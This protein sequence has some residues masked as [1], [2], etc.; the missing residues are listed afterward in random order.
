MKNWLRWVVPGLVALVFIIVAINYF[1][2]VAIPIPPFTTVAEVKLTP[3]TGGTRIML[4]PVGA[5]EAKTH[6]GPVLIELT[7][8][9]ID[10]RALQESLTH[11]QPQAKLYQDLTVIAEA[12]ARQLI[13]RV[14][15]ISAFAGLIGFLLVGPRRWQ[16]ALLG[17]LIGVALSSG[18]IILSYTS[19]DLAALESPRFTGMMEYAPWMISFVQR[20][21]SGLDDWSEQLNQMAKSIQT[22]SARAQAASDL[23]NAGKNPDDLVVLNISDIHNNPAG[24]QMVKGIIEQFQV[25]LVVDN[26]DTSDFGT[27]LEAS[28]V[29]AIADLNVRYLWVPGNHDSPEI[30]KKMRQIDNV[31]VLDGS[32]EIAGLKVAGWPDP[33]A[34]GNDVISLPEELSE[35]TE[36]LRDQVAGIELDFLVVHNHRV[37]QE[38]AGY[39][40][41]ILTGHSHKAGWTKAGETV[42]VNPGSTGAEGI[43]GLQKEAGTPYTA[44]L[45]YFTKETTEYSL[46]TI[47]FLEFAPDGIGFSLSRKAI[48]GNG[49]SLE[50]SSDG[51]RTTGL[52]S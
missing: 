48:K 47:D 22:L 33:A 30:I 5:I 9:A 50:K 42:I 21:I 4:P 10:L 37:A 3:Y 8:D 13:A 25:D 17:L 43:R 44:I 18:L 6:R 27:A 52:E 51:D 34:D 28:L 26:G 19:F 2:A 32:T 23:V 20:A 39:A 38:L 35:Y 29:S 46:T 7:L 36:F 14:L 41:L 1:S 15:I 31:I 45:L 12:A 11:E 16:S 24:Y 40:P 49:S